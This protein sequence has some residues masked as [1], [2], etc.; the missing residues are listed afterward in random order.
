MRCRLPIGLAQDEHVVV[1]LERDLGHRCPAA[2]AAPAVRGT[3]RPHRARTGT[4]SRAAH[5]SSSPCGRCSRSSGSRA[6]SASFRY[7]PSLTPSASRTRSRIV[8]PSRY[9]TR[10]LRR[11]AP[12]DRDVARGAE[13]GQREHR[14]LI[15]LLQREV[16]HHGARWYRASVARSC[17]REESGRRRETSTSPRYVSGL[18]PAPPKRVAQAHPGGE[19]LRARLKDVARRR[20][21]GCARGR[22]PGTPERRRPFCS[23]TAGAAARERGE[24]TSIVTRLA[25][26]DARSAGG[27]MRSISTRCCDGR[28]REAA[29]GAQQ[30]GE[31][32][33]RLHLVR[34]GTRDLAQ[35]AHARSVHRHED[36]VAGLQSHVV[37]GVAA[38]Q[39]V[40]DVEDVDGPAA[41]A[42]L[43]RTQASRWSSARP[44]RRA[45]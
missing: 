20:R 26:A 6:I 40:V 45:R 39:V 16:V 13:R 42:D 44:P 14:D 7:A 21:C 8:I 3:G 1:R 35:D 37:R 17:T 33:A 36:H 25:P 4:W 38:D 10:P 23:G 11:T 24:S 31:R 27:R 22:P 15:V 5:A 18:S 2:P 43:E 32:L 12:A 28:R 19:P 30:V 9:S 41:A 29:S 34:G